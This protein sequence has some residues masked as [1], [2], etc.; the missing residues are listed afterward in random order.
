MQNNKRLPLTEPHSNG[1]TAGTAAIDHGFEIVPDTQNFVTLRM[2]AQLP[3]FMVD[4]PVR[5][6]DFFGRES[7]LEQLDSCLLPP[8][9][10][11]YSS[12]PSLKRHIVLCG[13]GGL[14][15]SSIAIEFAFQRRDR[16]DAVFW[17]RADKPEKLEQ[18]LDSVPRRQ[19][20]RN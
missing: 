17:V 5:N 4:T 20:A 15:K 14:G 13:M 11:M 12:Q 16:F 8:E 9:N 10:S 19:L 1:A 3:C 18:G 6:P 2:Q 7:V